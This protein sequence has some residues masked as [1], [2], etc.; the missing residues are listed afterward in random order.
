MANLEKIELMQAQ[1]EN[2][3]EQKIEI[4]DKKGHFNDDFI[5]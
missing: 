2:K 4:N 5:V 1:L 3:G